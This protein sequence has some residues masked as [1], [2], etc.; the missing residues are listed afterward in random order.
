M[1][2]VKYDESISFANRR[3]FKKACQKWSKGSGVKCVNY[4][5]Q[6]DYL[7][8]TSFSDQSC[9][10]QVGTGRNGGVRRM[11][12]GVGCWT[13]FHLVHELGHAFGLMHEHQRP[14]RDKYITVLWDNIEPANSFNYEKFK[15]FKRG[16]QYDFKSV[17]HYPKYAFAKKGKVAFIVK[18]K[19]KNKVIKIR[20]SPSKKDYRI[21]RKIYGS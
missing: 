15:S 4:N 11:N 14:D 9:Y 17:M 12:I 16:T 13:A 2:P 20:K 5:K 7:Y 6:K 18:D 1:I 10:S 8:L 3:K 21:M 19:F